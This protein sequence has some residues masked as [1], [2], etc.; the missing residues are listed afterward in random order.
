MK[1][2]KQNYPYLFIFPSGT[3]YSTEMYLIFFPVCNS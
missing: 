3:L 2:L 1:Y